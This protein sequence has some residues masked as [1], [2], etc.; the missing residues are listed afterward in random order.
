M[1]GT[2]AFLE[3]LGIYASTIVA[4]AKSKHLAIVP[5]LCFNPSGV[6]V[7]KRIS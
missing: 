7:P 2:S 6:R 3:H 5:D 4:D 1:P